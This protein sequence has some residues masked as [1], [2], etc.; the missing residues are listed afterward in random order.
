M[1]NRKANEP[2][3]MM[4]VPVSF[5][6]HVQSVALDLGMDATK[7]LEQST[8]VYYRYKDGDPGS[9]RESYNPDSKTFL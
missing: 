9:K 1:A 7:M 3:V 4:R 6:K 5:Q 2:R 8:V